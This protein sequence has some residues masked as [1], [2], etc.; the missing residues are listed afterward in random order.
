MLLIM[1]FSQFLVTL[2]LLGPNI[3]N[4]LFSNTHSLRS[5]LNVSDHVSHPYKTTGNIRVLYISIFKFLDRLYYYYNHFRIREGS[6]AHCISPVLQM[7][8]GGILRGEK[9][10]R[11]QTEICSIP[12]WF[13][14]VIR[15]TL[16]LNPELC[17]GKPQVTLTLPIQQLIF[18]TLSQHVSFRVTNYVTRLFQMKTFSFWGQIHTAVFDQWTPVQTVLPLASGAAVFPSDVST[19]ALQ[20]APLPNQSAAGIISMGDKTDVTRN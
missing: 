3:L 11:A 13:A 1:Q 14:N 4:I 5:F 10:R 6:D 17:G 18:P 9:K 20:P 2:S 19:P 8:I 12:T 15:T 16:G 7:R